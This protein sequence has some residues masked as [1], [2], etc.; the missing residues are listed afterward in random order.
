MSSKHKVAL[1]TG[2]SSGIGNAVAQRFISEGFQVIIT[3]RNVEKLDLAANQL[4]S[5]CE[6]IP[7]DMAQLDDIPDFVRRVVEKYGSIDVL[8]NNA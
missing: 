4:G 3:G 8:V 6:G 5:Q 7:F 2:G 1:V